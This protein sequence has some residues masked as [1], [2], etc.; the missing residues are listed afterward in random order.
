MNDLIQFPSY[1]KS[2]P[3][4]DNPFYT[5]DL[6]AANQFT[7]T[8]LAMLLNLGP[9]D[10]AM[11]YGFKYV[12]GTGYL[13]GPSGVS[14]FYLGDGV[15]GGTFY[16]IS[17]TVSENSYLFGT[18]LD[19]QLQAFDD[20]NSR[21]IYTMLIGQSSPSN[22]APGIVF[23]PQLTG[24]MN[25]YRT[26]LFGMNTS[27]QSLL[28]T[29]AKLGAAAFMSTGTTAGT[30]AAGNDSRFGYSAAYI[31]SNFAKKTQVILTDSSTVFTPVNGNDPVNK[32]Y[33]DSLSA[34]R[35]A[36]G[37]QGIGTL[38]SGGAVY[39]IS[40]GAT[41]PNLNYRAY[42]TPWCQDLT[43]RSGGIICHLVS[44]ST[45]GAQVW[46]YPDTSI[47]QLVSV[48]FDVFGN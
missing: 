46:I 26:G 2:Y 38:V 40:Y 24:N 18:T 28:T 10:F 17:T 14:I 1:R 3:G 37:T 12:S 16:A 34:K 5:N 11:I 20:G 27:I 47:F 31:D 7:L 19:T 43:L 35:L 25:A 48:D 33:A 39:T 8:G 45:T 23:S 29:A 22:T 9:S 41:L 44:K 4:I 15:N 36:G 6:I 42:F 13:P 30:V 21:K 32:T